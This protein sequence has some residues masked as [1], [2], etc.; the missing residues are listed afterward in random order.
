MKKWRGIIMAAIVTGLVI[1]GNLTAWAGPYASYVD[2]RLRNQEA[3]I[4]K[5]WQ[6]GRLSPEEYQHLQAQHQRIRM[7]EHNM[8]ADGRLDPA[9]KTR[10]SEMLDHSEWSIERAVHKG[11]RW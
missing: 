5:A 1:C 2:Q 7:V 3:R 8:R 11:R 4:Q 9:E 10:L 6:S